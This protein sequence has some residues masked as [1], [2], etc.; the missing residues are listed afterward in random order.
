MTSVV[1]GNKTGVC[2]SLSELCMEQAALAVVTAGDAWDK[3]KITLKMVS[4]KTT[5]C[6]KRKSQH[7]QLN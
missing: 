7:A 2:N 3:C 1:M 5:K 4:V 6:K